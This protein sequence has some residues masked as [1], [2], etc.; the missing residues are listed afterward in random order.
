MDKEKKVLFDPGYAPLV[1]ESMGQIG[2]TYYVF[3]AVKDYKAKK[4]NFPHTLR[5]IE[6]LLKTNIAFYLGC[7]MWGL[8]IKQFDDYKIEGN[9]LL[10][11]KCDEEEFCSEINFLLDFVQNQLSKDSKYY[12]N[13]PYET[14]DGY[15]EILNTYKQFL[16]LNKGFVSCEKTNQIILPDNI[17]KLDKKGLEEINTKIQNAIKNE[18]IESL[19]DDWKTIL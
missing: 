10:G 1:I 11:E 7:L 14:P 13:K 8:Y 9:K 2:Y 17:K 4:L 5:K 19:L 16:I 12:L 6:R 15:V 18:N 3:A